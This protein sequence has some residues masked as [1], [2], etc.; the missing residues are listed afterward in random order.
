[1]LAQLR[2]ADAGRN[3]SPILSFLIAAERTHT[4]F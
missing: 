4:Q 3:H 2:V 1:M